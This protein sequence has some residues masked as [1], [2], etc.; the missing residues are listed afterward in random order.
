MKKRILTPDHNDW[1]VYIDK[2]SFVLRAHIDD[3]LSIN[4]CKNDLRYTEKILK[5]FPDIDVQGT[6]AFIKEE[7]GDCD[8]K[9][10]AIIT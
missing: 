7:F 4:N 5:S 3:E 6:I 8:C 10:L 9:V 1:E 2:L